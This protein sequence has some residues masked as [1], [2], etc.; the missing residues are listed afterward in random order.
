VHPAAEPLDQTEVETDILA[1]SG[2]VAYRVFREKRYGDYP[3]TVIAPEPL[4]IPARFD[5]QHKPEE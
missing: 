3:S 2:Q 4:E 5:W 1:N